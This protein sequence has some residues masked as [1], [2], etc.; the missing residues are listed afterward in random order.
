MC[1][2]YLLAEADP[3]LVGC[4]PK[5]YEERLVGYRK[6][7][8]VLHFGHAQY[9]QKRNKLRA[10]SIS[11]TLIANRIQQIEWFADACVYRKC[12]KSRSQSR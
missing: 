9:S 10:R 12:I 6:L 4:D 3:T 2:G 8:G 1:L 11:K 5:S 7:R